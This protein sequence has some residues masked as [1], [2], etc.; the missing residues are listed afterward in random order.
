[1]DQSSAAGRG[2]RKGKN[3]PIGDALPP[4]ISLEFAA[5]IPSIA[6]NVEGRPPPKGNIKKYPLW[7]Y[8]TREDG[9]SSKAKGG[10]NVN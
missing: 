9:P 5:N 8:V 3:V 2:Q 4:P 10:G 7:K 1:M 6:S